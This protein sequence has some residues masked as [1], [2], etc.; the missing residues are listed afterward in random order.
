M[1]EDWPQKDAKGSKTSMERP[2]FNL[3]PF[4][5]SCASLRPTSPLELT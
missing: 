1:K 2:S 5:D 3:L 4:C